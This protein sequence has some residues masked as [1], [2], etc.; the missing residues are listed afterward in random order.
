MKKPKLE[1]GIISFLLFLADSIL[2]IWE[3]SEGIASRIDL[4][5]DVIERALTIITMCFLFLDTMSAS[6]DSNKSYT[7]PLFYVIYSFA[8][9]ILS[10][11]ESYLNGS[12]KSII[13]LI[14]KL[15]TFIPAV[16]AYIYSEFIYRQ[17]KNHQG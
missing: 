2:I 3:L 1:S 16:S 14:F 15:V 9:F 10:I 8:L 13:S 7:I 17:R 4:N 12:T 6:N 5:R 11:L